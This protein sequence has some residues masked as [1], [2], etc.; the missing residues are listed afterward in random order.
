MYTEYKAHIR[1]YSV[2]L[3]Q[4]FPGCWPWC[5]NIMIKNFSNLIPSNLVALL[6][7]VGSNSASGLLSLHSC[8]FILTLSAIYSISL[9]ASYNTVFYFFDSPEVWQIGFQDSASQGLTGISDLHN[10]I[11]F[12]LILILLGVFWVLGAII[13][14]FNS[15]GSNFVHRYWNHGTAIELIWTIS[16]AF[17]LLAI[18]HPSFRLLYILDEVIEPILTI[19]VIGNQW[20]W[21][22]E[23]SDYVKESGESIS[24]ESYMI[25]AV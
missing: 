4:V 25:P 12:F 15:K 11:F 3:K 1:L 21:S 24:F 6:K 13:Y 9:R 19:K 5:F 10:S 7:A 2:N 18:A 20:F 17:I 22:F 14:L 8:L 23:Y 16:P